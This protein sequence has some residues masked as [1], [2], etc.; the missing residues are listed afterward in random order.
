MG[1]MEALLSRQSL[2][3]S[4]NGGCWSGLQ[5]VSTPVIGFL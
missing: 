5:V 4:P 3:E 2:V 1:L